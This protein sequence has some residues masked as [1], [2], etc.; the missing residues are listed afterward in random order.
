MVEEKIKFFYPIKTL[1]ISLTGE[2]CF[3]NCLHCS[4]S[5][6]KE[7]KTRETGFEILKNNDYSSVLISGGFNI[8]A[9]DL[10]S[11]VASHPDVTDV[12]VIGIPSTQWGET[13]LALVVIRPGSDVS[14]ETLRQ[15]ANEKVG[16]T[17]RLSALEFRQE[18]PR[19]ALGKTL[20]RE[21]RAPYWKE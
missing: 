19:S 1:P 7:M 17:Q 6:L 16:R 2:S 20:K 9:S 10:E 8:Y 3:L 15:W 4:G 11:V 18:L 13:P 21:L 14:E 12:A 5:Y